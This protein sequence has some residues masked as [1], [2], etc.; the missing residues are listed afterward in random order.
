MHL[1]SFMY[2]ISSSAAMQSVACVLSY[3]ALDLAQPHLVYRIV[4]LYLVP[5]SIFPDT[6]SHCWLPQGRCTSP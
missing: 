4:F 6:Q 2:S 1:Y 3:K 5:T